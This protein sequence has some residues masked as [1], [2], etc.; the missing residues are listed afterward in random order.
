[1]KPEGETLTDFPKPN[2]EPAVDLELLELKGRVEHG[3]FVGKLRNKSTGTTIRE[4]TVRITCK[5]PGEE[6]SRSFRLEV[7]SPPQSTRRLKLPIWWGRIGK[8]FYSIEITAA[9]R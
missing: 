1:M 8:E 4:I 3:Y 5:V 7:S 2:D 9:K 6:D